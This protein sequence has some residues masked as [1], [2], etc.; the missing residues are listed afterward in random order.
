MRISL[1]FLAAIAISSWAESVPGRG[2]FERVLNVSGPVDL[3]VL[4]EIGGVV[5]TV[6]PSD[7]V[8]VQAVL[9]P[10]FGPLDLVEA[11]RR[12]K[13]IEA[14]PPIQQTGNRIRIGYSTDPKQLTRISMRL[15]VQVPHAT[16][17]RA[18]TSSGGIE[19][20]G[21]Q[22]DVHGES[23][24]G[25]I[26]V[27]DIKGNV[28]AKTQSGGIAVRSCQGRVQVHNGS[29]AVEVTDLAGPIEATTGSGAIRLSQ[30]QPAPIRA[31]ARSGA[32]KVRVAAGAGYDY[33]ARSEK[34]EIFIANVHGN[35]A[36][37]KRELTGKL[38]EGGPLVD[39]STHSS[40]VS[41][42]R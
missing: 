34:G 38:G 9:T 31:R 7:S 27:A 32:I 8:R 36:K 28:T 12:I 30:R 3:D 18:L 11:T 29:G 42:E 19:V 14:N 4:S 35:K 41:I 25:R 10:Q 1:P 39:V 23:R 17:V 24:S 13:E 16:A 22:A 5:V 20:S 21:L 40:S 26:I 2:S 15:E 37:N 6:G 33:L